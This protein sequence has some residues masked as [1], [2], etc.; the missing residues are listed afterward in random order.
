MTILAG[1][2]MLLT[3][4]DVMGPRANLYI[5]SI[6][7]WLCGPCAVDSRCTEEKTQSAASGT[8]AQPISEWP[9][10]GY[11]CGAKREGNCGP[12]RA[13]ELRW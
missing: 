1:E 6:S 10:Y 13:A 7:V 5:I 2:F 3:I 8:H 11:G 4:S 12:S 9:R